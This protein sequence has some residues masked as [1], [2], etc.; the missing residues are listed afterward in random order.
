M[1]KFLAQDIFK[2]ASKKNTSIQ[3]EQRELKFPFNLS[4]KIIHKNSEKLRGPGIY[5]ATYKDE[6]IYVGSYSSNK[7]KII[8]D[9]WVKHIQTFTNRGYRLGFNAQTKIHLIP[10]LFKDY[11][12]KEPYRYCDTGTVTSLERLHFAAEFFHEF[13][14]DDNTILKDFCFYYKQLNDNM[15]PKK[16]ESDLIREFRPRCN[17]KTNN[18]ESIRGISIQSCMQYLLSTNVT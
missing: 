4:F 8:Q 10:E 6:V 7:P 3:R 11:F 15:N 17:S 14:I 1:E 13:N 18:L 2:I 9:R 16:I 5:F 12:A